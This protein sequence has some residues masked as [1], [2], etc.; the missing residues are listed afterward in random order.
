MQIIAEGEK[1]LNNGSKRD[2]KALP[3]TISQRCE[4]EDYIRRNSGKTHQHTGKSLTQMCCN[5]PLAM[6]I[7]TLY[8][9]VHL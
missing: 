1:I 3:T 2:K 5:F 6:E 9:I 7:I 8:N 4:M